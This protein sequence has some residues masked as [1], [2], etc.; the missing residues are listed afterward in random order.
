[1][2]KREKP[3]EHEGFDALFKAIALDNSLDDAERAKLL[4]QMEANAQNHA[5]KKPARVIDLNAAR[6]KKQREQRGRK[7]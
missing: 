7:L 6:A 5:N 1:M 2:N 4:M 3:T